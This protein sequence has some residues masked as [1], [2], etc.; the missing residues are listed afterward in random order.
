MPLPAL[1]Q[2]VLSLLSVVLFPTLRLPPPPPTG[3]I[4][5]CHFD[6]YDNLLVQVCGYKFCRLFAPSESSKLYCVTPT[7]L[8]APGAPPVRVGSGGPSAEA[9]PSPDATLGQGNV[10]AVD[11]EHPDLAAHPLAEGAH[12]WD[13]LLGPGD[14]LFIPAGWWHMMRSLTVGGGRVGARGDCRWGGGTGV[15]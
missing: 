9:A 3:T 6:T 12:H 7:L 15:G 13:A 10:S 11:V 2:A 1:T 14:T 5:R 8:R 4:T